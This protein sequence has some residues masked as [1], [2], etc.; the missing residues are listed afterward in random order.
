M[1]FSKALREACKECG[2]VRNAHANAGKG[3]CL[4]KGTRCAGYEPAKLKPVLGTELKLSGGHY[5]TLLARNKAGWEGL[6]QATSMVNGSEA[7][8]IPLEVLGGLAKG[9]LVAHSGLPESELAECIFA[10]PE[11]AWAA[12][13]YEEAK[14]FL[15]D[16]KDIQK[17]LLSR[18][19]AYQ[20]VFGK[21]QFYLAIS[22][23]DASNVPAL[24]LVAK[25]LRWA[26]KQTGAPCIASDTALYCKPA[27]AVD[28]RAILA[29]SEKVTLEEAPTKISGPLSRFFCSN[30]AF[31][32]GLPELRSVYAEDE[33]K[34]T[35]QLSELCS[36]F[37][38][39]GP[40]MMPAV[41]LPKGKT[42]EE[43]LKDLCRNGWREKI[44]GVIPTERETEYADRI[45][46]ELS[47]FEKAGL[48]PYFL[49][50]EDYC[51]YAMRDG[52]IIGRARGSAGGCLTSYL[53]GIID[54][55]PVLCGLYF[56][57]FYNDGRNSPGRIAL[58]DIDTDFP[59]EKR[60]DVISYIQKTY[61][62]DYVGYIA[63]FG[64]IM[65]ASSI[66]DVFRIRGRDSKEANKVTDFVPDKDKIA[67]ELQEM[68]EEEG[69]A[70]V[71]RWA[72]E[73]KSRELSPWA[74]MDKEGNITGPYAK[75]FEQAIRLEGTRRSMGRHPSGIVVS[76][77]ILSEF[78]PMAYPGGVPV[79]AMEMNSCE[80]AGLIKL[81][82]LGVSVLSKLSDF[83]KLTRTGTME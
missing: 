21:D 37:D 74:K 69:E 45:K 32:P 73:H 10:K 83:E 67:D 22:L 50:V 64:K 79:I 28:H 7:Q 41:S 59:V 62:H 26:S 30:K 43:H 2:H 9:N 17:E 14:S 11:G 63:T 47:V 61:G 44:K 75:D 52:G 29:I 19:S 4:V 39:T 54:L 78:M 70:S 5:V 34:N 3:K 38:I 1:E 12:K 48:A 46:M 6:A 49:V 18:I 42:A 24:G 65:G 27:D 55:D 66:K 31:L 53:L 36:D 76:P 81:D 51:R 13:S 25:A 60:D 33:L 20:S 8:E 72:L 16:Q 56:E 35:I 57:R 23:F 40:P 77:R 68:I 80:M 58:P 15:K 82:I 71:L